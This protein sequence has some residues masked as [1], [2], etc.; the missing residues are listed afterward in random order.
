[1][2][3]VFLMLIRPR[4]KASASERLDSERPAC[5]PHS[6]PL[7]AAWCRGVKPQCFS[8]QIAYLLLNSEVLRFQG[9]W[10][11]HTQASIIGL[12]CQKAGPFIPSKETIEWSQLSFFPST[13]D[14]AAY[15]QSPGALRCEQLRFWGL[16]HSGNAPHGQRLTTVLCNGRISYWDFLSPVRAGA[17]VPQ[18]SLRFCRLLMEARLTGLWPWKPDRFT[19]ST[20]VQPLTLASLSWQ[21][22]DS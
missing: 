7:A 18:D 5:S 13:F 4:T 17:Q 3:C 15:L 6:Q 14:L 11:L 8:M 20:G 2:L 22:W 9:L 12:A 21:A 1:M 19:W 10:A 16:G